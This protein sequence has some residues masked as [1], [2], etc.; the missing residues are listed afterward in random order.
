MEGARVL[1]VEDNEVN[2]MVAIQFLKKKGIKVDIANN[3]YSALEKIILKEYDLVLMD[4]QMPEMDGYEASR[5]IRAMA[6]PYF[7]EVPL[8]ALTA[9]TMSEVRKK[10]AASGMTDYI[11]KPFSP[12]TLYQTLS[13]YLGKVAM[14]KEDRSG[15][16]SRSG[17]TIAFDKVMEFAFGEKS[18]YLELLEKI[19]VELQ[20]FNAE[21]LESI[22]KRD[23]EHV[24]FLSHRL[25]SSLKILELHALNNNIEKVR[26]LL[27]GPASN[28]KEIKKLAHE[29]DRQCKVAVRDMGM[30]LE[31]V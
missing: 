24:G 16:S 17:E 8:I 23:L 1:L 14:K 22:D 28:Q 6:G 25:S 4:L 7:A 3:G 5:R 19:Q 13:K 27:Q 30:E 31:K 10:V 2:Q 18:F 21:F 15:L 26:E 20:S 29:I 9:S 12:D 11:S